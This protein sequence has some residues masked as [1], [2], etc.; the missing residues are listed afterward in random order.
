M[1]QSSIYPFWKLSEGSA[2]E[3]QQVPYGLDKYTGLLNV[4]LVYSEIY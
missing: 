2:T 1:T 4:G 3:D